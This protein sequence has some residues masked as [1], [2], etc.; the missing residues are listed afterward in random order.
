MP[1]YIRVLSRSSETVPFD[2]LQEVLSRNGHSANL[3]L[4][5]GSRESWEQLLLAHMDGTEIAVIERN[6]VERNSLGAEELQEFLIAIEGGKPASAEAWLRQYLATVS[7]I[8]AFQ[9]LNGI[10][11]GDGWSAVSCLQNTLR[12]LGGILQADG[13]GFSNEQGYHIL[14]E[15]SDNV[16]GAWSMGVLRDAEWIH[17]QMDLGNRNHREAFLRGEVPA[18]VEIE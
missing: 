13:E 10:N 1:Y 3:S 11:A 18:G 7:T 9:L 2:K 4:E 14:W 12:S 6:P 16:T 8:Y 15:F 17:F 5:K